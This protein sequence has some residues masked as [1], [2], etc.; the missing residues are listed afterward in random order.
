MKKDAQLRDLNLQSRA[1]F[2]QS[3]PLRCKRQHVGTTD[4]FLPILFIQWML[5]SV[6]SSDRKLKS[7][8]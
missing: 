4:V 8:Q 6:A 3:L 2:Q 5:Q 1:Y 7:E